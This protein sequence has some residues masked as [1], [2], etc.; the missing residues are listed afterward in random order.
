MCVCV[1][2]CVFARAR[3]CLRKAAMW[4]ELWGGGAAPRLAL[5]EPFLPNQSFGI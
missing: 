3:I 5:G 4:T 1:C 2:V